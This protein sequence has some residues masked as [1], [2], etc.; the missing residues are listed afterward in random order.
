MASWNQELLERLPNHSVK[1]IK[2]FIFTRHK[3]KHAQKNPLALSSS[4]VGRIT[5]TG[6]FKHATS[7]F[8]NVVTLISKAAGSVTTEALKVPVPRAWAVTQQPRA[9]PALGS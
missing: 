7:V 4:L 2:S 8:S 3:N 6:S 9:H 5:C 1:A